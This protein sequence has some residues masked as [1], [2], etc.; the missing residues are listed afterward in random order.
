MINDDKQPRAFILLDPLVGMI[1]YINDKNRQDV[2]QALENGDILM[3]Q[4][5]DDSRDFVTIEEMD[6]YI[7]RKPT[8]GVAVVL[9]SHFVPVLESLL[10]LMEETMQPAVAVLSL[11]SNAKRTVNSKFDDFKSKAE[12]LLN[13]YK[14][15]LGD[16]A[17]GN[18]E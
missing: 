5:S 12:N 4:Y 10:E 3:V 1:T 16:D 18:S 2:P 11:N 9:Q 15:N 17:D 8:G 14:E 13:I 6:E 7:N